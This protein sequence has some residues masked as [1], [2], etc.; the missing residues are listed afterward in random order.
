MPAGR[1]ESKRGLPLS[2]EQAIKIS[3]EIMSTLADRRAEMESSSIDDA[4]AA[5]AALFVKTF[6]GYVICVRPA[7]EIDKA[8]RKYRTGLL[9]R[10]YVA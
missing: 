1:P 2:F 5:A 6:F 10:P 8:V 9:G 3:I 4:A 7:R